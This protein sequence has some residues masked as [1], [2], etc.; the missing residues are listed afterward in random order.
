ME[1]EEFAAMVRDIRCVEKALGVSDY[2]LTPQQEEEH[3]GV[4]SLF[5]V[6]DVAEGELLTSDNIRSIRPGDGLAPARIDE[7]LG[8]RA[9]H[10]L[11]RGEPLREGDFVS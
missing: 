5:V 7:I 8:K 10:R 3:S 9:A 2:R 4:R 1:P 11:E 6:K